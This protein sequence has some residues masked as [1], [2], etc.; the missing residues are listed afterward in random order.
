MILTLNDSMK[1]AN[2]KDWDQTD[3]E[4]YKDDIPWDYTI[5]FDPMIDGGILDIIRNGR[6]V[7]YDKR[8]I[9]VTEWIGNTMIVRPQIIYVQQLLALP[10]D[11]SALSVT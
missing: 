10:S 3:W 1:I 2:V 6:E 8:T 4:I 7:H 11:P 9:Y 5:E